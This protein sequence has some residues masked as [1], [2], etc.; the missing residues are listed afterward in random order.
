MAAF[1]L[2]TSAQADQVR[3]PSIST[4]LAALDPVERQDGLFVLGSGVLSDPAH[5]VHR[6]FLGTLLQLDGNDASFP[7]AIASVDA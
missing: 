6:E 5:A 2:L 4:P 3:G 7:P 1:I